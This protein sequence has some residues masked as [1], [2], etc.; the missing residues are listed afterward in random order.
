M[1]STSTAAPGVRLLARSV[2]E[3]VHRVLAT[4][5]IIGGDKPLAAA[6]GAMGKSV[7]EVR[8]PA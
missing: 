6:A 7:Y 8:M 2:D 4:E 5:D 1:V 3:Y